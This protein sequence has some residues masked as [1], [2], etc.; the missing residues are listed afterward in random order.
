MTW[1]SPTL[2]GFDESEME[3]AVCL[4][5]RLPGGSTTRVASLP[6]KAVLSP[7]FVVTVTH[8]SKGN[9]AEKPF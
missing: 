4:A 7:T 5:S 6:L 8:T 1:V 2:Y 9:G 3:K